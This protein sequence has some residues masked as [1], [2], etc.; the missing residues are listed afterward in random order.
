MS[1]VAS[2]WSVIVRW[3][4]LLILLL[5]AFLR[6]GDITEQSFW[7]DEGNTLRLVQRDSAALIDAA[8]RDIHPPG[9]YLTLKVWTGLI[10]EQELG[11][12][13]LSAFWGLLAVAGTYALGT[14]LYARHAGT[15]A[16][17]LVAV[18]AFSIY[19][20]QEAR[21]YA[22]L[23]ALAVIS[24][25]V[26]MQMLRP[27][28]HWS[29]GI[30]LALVNLW[31]LYTHYTYPLT[32]LVQG[33]F[34]V[35]W[36][37]LESAPLGATYRK[38]ILG[39]F[40]ILNVITIACFLPWLPTAY[41]QLT[42]WPSDDTGVA[43]AEKLSTISHTITYGEAAISVRGLDWFM[44]GLL[45]VTIILPDWYLQRPRNLWR[46]MLPIVWIVLVGGVLL[47]S[48]AYR[49]A[50]LKFLLPAQIGVA[51][52][53]GRGAYLLWD[54][55]SVSAATPLEILP[56][57]VAAAAYA[58]IGITAWEVAQQVKT[59][60]VFHR[61]DYRQ[62]AQVIDTLETDNTA[63]VL[64]A[65]GQEEVFSYYY[66]GRSELYP[67]P[68]GLGGDDAATYQEALALIDQYSQIMVLFWGE[69]ERD[70]NGIVKNTLDNNAFEISSTWYG[71]VRLV[72]YGVLA[73][74]PAEPEIELNTQFG[75][76]I[77]L[78]G[79]AI[80]G[81]FEASVLGIT[82]FWQTDQPLD[83]RYKVFVQLLYP[84]GTLA[85][86]HDSEPANNTALTIDWQPNQVVIDNHGLVMPTDLPEGVYDVIVGV[87]ALDDPQERLIVQETGADALVVEQLTDE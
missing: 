42:T 19:Y 12:R 17:L 3:S 76:N 64:N 10:G 82:L 86:Q 8:A 11:L 80:Q 78:M 9:Y 49:D 25:W 83:T 44:L 31:G 59:D 58:T 36:L 6:I 57:V 67:L 81:G 53:L 22:Q 14:R 39:W 26:F 20:S 1:I 41:D 55:G 43:F 15:L 85:A 69:G 63:I 45:G 2:G 23:M 33:I 73:A 61:H 27:R 35:W 29:W 5:A 46:V 28:A 34:F 71:D 18:N 66:N 4:P 87:Y 54:V 52:L 16:A 50:N 62:M 75:E 68:R 37:V 40:V 65:P 51:L 30:A 48:G 56:R 74:P 70:P 84:D 77:T 79:Y 47:V 72:R 21:M 38:Q 60:P 13:S 24:L 32:M 7:N